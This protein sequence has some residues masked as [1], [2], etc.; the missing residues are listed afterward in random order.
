MARTGMAE[1]PCLE[2]VPPSAFGRCQR[3]K[4]DLI[5]GMYTRRSNQFNEVTAVN[6]PV[7]AFTEVFGTVFTKPSQASHTG[8]VPLC[9]YREIEG[10]DVLCFPWAETPP[11]YDQVQVVPEDRGYIYPP[12]FDVPSSPE[13]PRAAPANV[14]HSCILNIDDDDLMA[15]KKEMMEFHLPN[16]ASIRYCKFP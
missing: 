6:R 15:V 12:S 13:Q 14:E 3:N 1:P 2:R 7:N 11:C 16:D 8:A 5:V 4:S 9:H 10:S